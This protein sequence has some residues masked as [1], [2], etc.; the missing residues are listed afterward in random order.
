MNQN[1][2]KISTPA[3]TLIRGLGKRRYN[4]PDE[5]ILYPGFKY[6][7]RSPNFK[8]PPYQPSKLFR[9]KRIKSMKGLPYWEK[10]ILT[11]FKLDGKDYAVIKN[12]PENNARLWK[13]KHTIEIVPIT[14]PDG[15]PNETDRTVLKE[16]GELRIIR[17]VGDVDKQLQLA[18]EFRMLTDRMD[19]DTLR[20]N[21]RKQWL[22]GDD[23]FS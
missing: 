4:W 23:L 7:P 8:D 17:N 22:N 18:D 12:I 14:F 1:F 3:L 15:F 9:V 11:E 20:R 21:L 10:N 2:L 19:G 5:G 16:N 13:V 6:Y